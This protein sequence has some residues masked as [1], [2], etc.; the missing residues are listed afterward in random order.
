MLLEV[1][2]ALLIFSIGILGLVAM[3]TTAVRQSSDAQYRSI[4]A[5]QAQNLI[6]QMWLT[7]HATVSTRFATGGT[8]Y[9]TWFTTLQSAG[10]PQVAAKPPT[11]S[12][13]SGSNLAT[14][15]IYWKAPGEADTHQYVAM[16][17]VP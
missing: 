16:A 4:A 2:C 15:T 12:F 5:L 10:L 14:I 11:V 9:S 7:D 13:V 8:D 1:L 3:Q 17:Q 6:S